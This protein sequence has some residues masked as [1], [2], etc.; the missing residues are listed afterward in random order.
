MMGP[1]IGIV[2]TGHLGVA[3]ASRLVDVG[4]ERGRVW[5]GHRGS[6]ASHAISAAAGMA[7]RLAHVDEVIRHCDVLLYSVRPA[8]YT[9]LSA[10]ALRDGQSVISFLAGVSLERLSAVVR[11]HGALTRAIISAPDTIARGQSLG[12]TYGG[13]D[14]RARALLDAMGTR[15]L[16]VP[17]EDRFEPVTVLGTCLPFILMYCEHLDIAVREDDIVQSATAFGLGEWREIIAW[18]HRVKPGRPSAEEVE[19]QV[20]RS[21]TPGGIAEKIMRSLREHGDFARTVQDS[22]EHART[23]V[24]A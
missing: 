4:F 22:V 3:I 14:A 15:L 9:M 7:D 8:D 6:Q 16:A 13:A 24:P 17:S 19:R 5:L 23:M 12:V 2:G 21:A 11:G 18:A 10:Y 1:R 20:N